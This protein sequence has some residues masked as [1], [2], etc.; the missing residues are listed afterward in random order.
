MSLLTTRSGP[1]MHAEVP[2]CRDRASSGEVVPARYSVAAGGADRDRHRPR[3]CSRCLLRNE[4]SRMV[5]GVATYDLSS[6]QW[7]PPSLDWYT[8]VLY[9]PSIA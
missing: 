5:R 3:C 8:S 6:V 7:W 1:F 9:V 4:T 2:L